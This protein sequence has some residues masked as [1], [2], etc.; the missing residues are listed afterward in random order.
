MTPDLYDLLD[1]HFPTIVD[2]LIYGDCVEGACEHNTEEVC[3]LHPV[4]VCGRCMVVPEIG[5]VAFAVE[6]PCEH[7]VGGQHRV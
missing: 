6:W 1:V 4:M 7:D 5:D 2:A 3:P